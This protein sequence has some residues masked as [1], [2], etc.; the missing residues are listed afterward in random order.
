[1]R[2]ELDGETNFRD[3][4]GFVGAEERLVRS[5]LLFRS[6]ELSR[7][8]DRDLARIQ[9]LGIRNVIDL[10]TEGERIAKPNRL[11]PSIREYHYP[12]LAHLGADSLDD[13]FANILHGHLN[14]TTYML[15]IYRGME[16]SKVQN[17]KHI[18]ALLRQ[19]E[20]TLWHC[21]AGKDRTGMTTA[22]ILEALGVKRAAILDDYMMT[23]QYSALSIESMMKHF[24]ERFG[25]EMALKLIDLITVKPEYLHAFW[26]AIQD[27]FGCVD[28][29]FQALEMEP[30]TFQKQFLER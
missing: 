1:M 6:G 28:G 5:G 22:L 21:T 3:L 29:L 10:R 23:N 26:D 14:A 11:P 12:L 30:L 8:S 27:H 4:G 15:D 7:T 20:P 13:L 17:W 18:F 16:N 19:G 9:N 24:R 2:I 25:D